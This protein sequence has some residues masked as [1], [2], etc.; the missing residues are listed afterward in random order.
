MILQALHEYYQRKMQD[1]DPAQRLA[2]F[3]LE[4]KEIPFVLELSLEGMLIAIKDTREQAG[5]K[6]VAS[7]FLVPK[8]VKKT[9]GVAANFLWDT[10][11]YVIGVDLR[12]K[13]GRVA[14]QHEAF[15]QRIETLPE[16]V[17]I[18]VGVTAV[19]TFLRGRP[20]DEVQ[21]DPLWDEVRA[22]SNP[23]LTFR[24]A[25]DIDLVCQRPAVV[26]HVASLNE[27]DPDSATGT[28][29]VTGS[30]AQLERLHS[31]IK[32]VWG[33]QSSGANI[34]SFNLDAFDSYGKDQGTN[35]PVGISA[36]FAYTT[37]LNHLLARDSRQRMQIG[38]ASTVFWT[39]QPDSL[40]D[41]FGSFFAQTT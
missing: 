20:L 6:K 2:A 18:D 22:A 36:A 32:G 41:A 9:S 13:A 31:A 38:D 40:E 3:G 34:V 10:A 28:C 39:Q 27:Q 7:K 4:N 19:R 15:L 14:E 5:R 23:T 11:E 16:A 24:L 12:G 35:A 26:S 1:P 17:K 30:N 29:L 37:A 33:A 21:Q 25:G 8:G